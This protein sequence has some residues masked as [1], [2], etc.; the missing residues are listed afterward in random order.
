MLIF[1][2]LFIFAFI[3]QAFFYIF[4]F[5]KAILKKSIIESK[6]S[7]TNNPVSIIICARNEAENLKKNLPLILEQ[8]YPN[9]EVIVVDDRSEDETEEILNEFA[10]KYSHLKIS[11]VKNEPKFI[12]G[13]KLALMLGIKSA[14]NEWLL[15][16]DADC[17]PAGN[18]WLSMMQR[19]FN[20]NTD[21]VLGYG[22][23]LK[24]PGFLNMIIRFET[25][26]TAMLYFGMARSGKPYMGVGR[27]LAY[28]KS[29]FFKNNGFAT[30]TNLASGDDDLFVNETANAGNTAIEIHPGSFTWSVAEKNFKDWYRQKK[31]HLTTGSRYKKGTKFRLILEN[32][33][34]VILL[35][36]FIFLLVKSPFTY[37]VIGAYCIL[38]LFKTFIFKSV[39]KQLNER[40]LFLSSFILEPFFPLF[41]SFIHFRNFID[42]K[43]TVWK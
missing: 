10:S 26:Y 9:F 5:R 25:A 7:S 6:N 33:S 38:Y 1:S 34:R 40:F 11:R 16:T 4:Y 15:F 29:L 39:F 31:R 3:I 18:Q 28:R 30:H 32:L 12:Y 8:D 42:R 24:E 35:I 13:K 20:Q 22:G 41:Y 14:V 19:N 37:Y 2:G 23:Y 21:I 17:K 27:N 36:S 43:R